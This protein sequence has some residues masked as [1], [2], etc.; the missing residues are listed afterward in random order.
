MDKKKPKCKKLIK[1]YLITAAHQAFEPN[2]SRQIIKLLFVLINT[3]L[4]LACGALV[5]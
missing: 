4:C 1:E 2:T 3:S 5:L